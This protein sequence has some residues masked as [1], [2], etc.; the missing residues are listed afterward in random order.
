VPLCTGEPG[1]QFSFSPG[2]SLLLTH[3]PA[4]GYELMSSWAGTTIRRGRSRPAVPHLAQ[5]EEDGLVRSSWDTEGTG[6]AR[7]IYEIT[8][9]GW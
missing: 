8:E 1:A 9:E 2:C 5:F 4:H 6:A 7:R 3:K